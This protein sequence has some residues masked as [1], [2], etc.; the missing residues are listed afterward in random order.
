MG[1]KMT[2]DRKN[3]FSQAARKEAFES[4]PVLPNLAFY[5]PC[6]LELLNEMVNN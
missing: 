4:R 6:P 3:N 2:K 5:C 1:E